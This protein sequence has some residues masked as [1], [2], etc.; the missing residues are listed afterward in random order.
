MLCK[1]LHI[2]K[3]RFVSSIFHAFFLPFF[4][5][6]GTQ[7]SLFGW[8]VCRKHISAGFF[9]LSLLLIAHSVFAQSSVAQHVYDPAGRL[10]QTIK[11][12]NTSVAY[13]YDA[14]G[15]ITSTEQLGADSLSII[16]FTPTTGLAGTAV[17]I[18]GS[19]FAPVAANNTV[20]FN[21]VEAAIQEASATKLKVI[22]PA[23]ASTG[24]ISVS[25]ANG[26]VTSEDSFIV[27]SFFDPYFPQ[28]INLS[29]NE[30][31]SFSFA[32]EQGRGYMLGLTDVVTTTGSITVVVKK[33]DATNLTTCSSIK[34]T[35][36]CTIPYLPITGNYTVIITA[37][38]AS[39]S[40]S[41][42]LNRDINGTLTTSVSET[43]IA[44][45]VGQAGTYDFEAAAGML[46]RLYLLGNTILGNTTV[47]LYRPDGVLHQSKTVNSVAG[48]EGSTTLDF[49]NLPAD[50]TY[51]VRLI[52]PSGNAMG[53]MQ[54]TLVQDISD[55]AIINGSNQQ[56]SLNATQNAYFTFEG[57]AGQWLG[58]GLEDL[59]VTPSNGSLS[60]TVLKPDG[61]Q[62][63]NFT[64]RS[65]ASGYALPKL[66]VT[67]TY[68]VQIVPGTNT[69][70]FKLLLTED[71]RGVLQN[72]GAATR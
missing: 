32:G 50:G 12:D 33:P 20:T 30:S 22:V 25:N 49:V 15:N 4:S 65:P 56:V 39:A 16:R 9:L 18:Y 28:P 11:S 51:R 41:V 70:S 24:P 60:V 46:G 66:P 59:E 68:K 53:G 35:A 34:K 37:V 23:T 64:A 8:G 38:S 5:L 14:V 44:D 3:K 19:G 40:L 7:S 17:T 21:G 29:A 47:Q 27:G 62:L 13:R 54:V 72:I 57:T 69:A 63:G 67:G 36:S 31:R 10:I 58:L 2:W 42:S 26:T 43:F 71:E 1:S 45:K 48:S 52:P 55:V 6:R 61:S